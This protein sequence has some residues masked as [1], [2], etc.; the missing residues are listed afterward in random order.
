MCFTRDLIIWGWQMDY[1]GL[2]EIDSQNFL[3]FS[4]NNPKLNCTMT[5]N[6]I[7]Y[8]ILLNIEQRCAVT[9]TQLA[10]HADTG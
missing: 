10:P 6:Q 4:C 1:F 8:C 9:N 7:N 3:L 5:G 2:D